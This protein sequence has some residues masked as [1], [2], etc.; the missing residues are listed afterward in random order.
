VETAVVAA[1][2]SSGASIV[3]AL[4]NT[5]VVL[6]SARL[7]A[8]TSRDVV[9]LQ[10]KLK[11]QEI[12]EGRASE[13]KVT[14]DLYRDPLLDASW[15]LG[16]RIDGIRNWQFL[17]IYLRQDHPL[18]SDALMTTLYR[19]G[20][21]LAWNEIVRTKLRL[22]KFERERDTR[23]T[24]ELLANIA[25]VLASGDADNSLM[26]WRDHQRAIGEMMIVHT[27]DGPSCMNY[28]SFCE[29]YEQRFARWFGS[30]GDDLKQGSTP[31]SESLAMLHTGLAELVDQLDEEKR[32][33]PGWRRRSPGKR[34][35]P[36]R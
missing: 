20:Q 22:L 3:I 8:D 27:D 26:L 7:Q 21:Y 19:I 5:V 32:Y 11:R 17:P 24:A 15:H 31:A 18:G 4:G 2:I 30:F 16:H 9:K 13:A 35:P 28:A 10:D 1:L 25:R 6:R 23:Q 33:P 12:Q 36:P 29:Q 34:P 14:L